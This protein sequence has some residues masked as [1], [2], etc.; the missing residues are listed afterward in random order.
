MITLLVGNGYQT[1]LPRLGKIRG[2]LNLSQKRV[3]KAVR[4]ELRRQYG[5][6]YITVSCAAA[7]AVDGWRGSCKI[8]GEGFG[9][10]IK[11]QPNR[12]A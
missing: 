11:E 7:L 4:E 12:S 5:L 3:T 9:F 6:P 1:S 8:H 10:S 2:V